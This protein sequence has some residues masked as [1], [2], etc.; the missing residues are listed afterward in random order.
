[1]NRARYHRS[2][3]IQTGHRRFALLK[4]KA[5]MTDTAGKLKTVRQT[6]DV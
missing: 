1:V 2:G 6:Y 5:A 3:L 4:R